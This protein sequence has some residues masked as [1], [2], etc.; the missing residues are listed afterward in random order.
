MN[1]EKRSSK[2]IL[3]RY[4]GQGNVERIFKFIKN[5]AWAESFC[6]NTPSRIRGTWLYLIDSRNDLYPLGTKYYKSAI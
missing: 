6:L 5:P 4:K 2:D 3:Q 1:I